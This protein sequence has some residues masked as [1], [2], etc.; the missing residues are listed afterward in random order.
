MRIIAGS[1]RGRTLKS[2]QTSMLRPT[3]DRVRESIFNILA[4]RFEFEGARALD[5]FA[6]TGALGIEALSRGA[7]ECDFVESD[8]RAAAVI[9]DNLLTLGVAPRGRVI[10]RDAL[11]FLEESDRSYDLIFAD[12]PYATTIFERLVRAIASEGRLSPEGLF[13][14]EHAGS[15]AAPLNAGL[16]LVT[17]RGFGDTGISIYA[18]A[19]GE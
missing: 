8:R 2:T 15:M 10:T 7:G 4:A 17:A 12:P 19:P 3:T 13:V 11:K 5:L 1:L 16:E 14:L 18:M 6:G 9:T